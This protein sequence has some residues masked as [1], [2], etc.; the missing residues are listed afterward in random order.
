MSV[1]DAAGRVYGGHVVYGNEVR[2]TAEILLAPLPD[3]SLT[4]EPD[5]VTGFQELVV[6]PRP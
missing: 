1:A 4:R 6:R 2:T 3:W 5:P